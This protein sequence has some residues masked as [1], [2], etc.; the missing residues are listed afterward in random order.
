[1]VTGWAG[2]GSIHRDRRCSYTKYTYLLEVLLD[3]LQLSETVEIV[4]TVLSELVPLL[5][6]RAEH[7]H[8]SSGSVVNN[9]SSRVQKRR[10]IT[11]AI[12]LGR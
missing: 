9:P 2:R 12:A 1:M 4:L 7:L 6:S 5:L 10:H 11:D 3:L 8:T